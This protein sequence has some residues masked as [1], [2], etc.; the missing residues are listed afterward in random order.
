MEC[1][2]QIESDF[3]TTVVLFNDTC[4]V[5]VDIVAAMSDAVRPAFIITD[6]QARI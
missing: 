2:V 4:S 1:D 3:V 5:T 6:H